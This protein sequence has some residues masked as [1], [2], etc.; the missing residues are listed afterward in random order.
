[1]SVLV[2]NGQINMLLLWVLLLIVFLLIEI[3]NIALITIWPAIGAF[4]A[5]I[6]A[7]MKKPDLWQIGAFGV[8]TIMTFFLFRPAAIKRFNREKHRIRLEKMIGKKAIVTST[9][10]NR[11]NIGEAVLNGKE[12]AARTWKSKCVVPVGSVV[13]VRAIHESLLLIEPVI[14]NR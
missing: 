6:L 14:I 8:G 3:K 12:W 2:Q 5:A 9:I 11:Q 10:D 13:E 7:A 1:M 4:I